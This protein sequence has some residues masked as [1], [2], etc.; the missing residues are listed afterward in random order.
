V[1]PGVHHEEWNAGDGEVRL[2]VV[3]LRHQQTR[4]NRLKDEGGPARS[5]DGCRDGVH[6][7]LEAIEGP[8]IADDGV[9]QRAGGPATAPGPQVPPEDRVEDMARYVEREGLLERGHPAEIIKRPG[10]FELG[11]RLVRLRHVG[12]MVRAVVKLHQFAGDVGLERTEVVGQRRKRVWTHGR[13]LSVR[14]RSPRATTKK[15]DVIERPQALHHVGLLFDGPPDIAEVPHIPSSDEPYSARLE[16]MRLRMS[17]VTHHFN[18]YF[19]ASNRRWRARGR[20]GGVT[21]VLAR[22]STATRRA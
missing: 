8:E 11:D 4:A 21:G 1:L 13:S 7:P 3:D 12:G 19:G 14:S 5:R 22:A 2:M 6:L 9:T 16:P 17:P 18:Q 10:F 15:A 20:S